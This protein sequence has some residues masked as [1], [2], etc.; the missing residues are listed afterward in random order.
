M[1]LKLSIKQSDSRICAQSIALYFLHI[2]NMVTLV[3]KEKNCFF[4]FVERTNLVI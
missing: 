2:Q 3:N 4:D 1:E